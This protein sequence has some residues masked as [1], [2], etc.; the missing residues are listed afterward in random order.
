MKSEDINGCNF[1]EG[2][3][4]SARGV[5]RLEIRRNAYCEAVLR[6]LILLMCIVIVSAG[7]AAAADPPVL[8]DDHA[9][10]V[11]SSREVVAKRRALIQYLW[12]AEGFPKRRMPDRVL[13]NAPSPVSRLSH[14]ARVDEIHVNQMVD[15]EAVTFHFIARHPN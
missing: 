1:V 13:T 5:I 11:H 8:V 9:I 7:S 2:L 12:G 14:L 10:T 6:F 4:H 15:L 3:R